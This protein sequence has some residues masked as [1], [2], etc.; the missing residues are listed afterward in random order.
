M[1]IVP[2]EE[3]PKYWCGGTLISNKLV[4]SGKKF[5][6]TTKIIFQQFN[7][8]YL[9]K[10]AAHCI[11]SKEGDNLLAREILVVLGSFKLNLRYEVGRETRSV[12][13]I[14]IHTDWNPFLTTYD[15]DIA[16]IEFEYPVTFSNYIQPICLWESPFD[17]SQSSGTVVGY[18]KSEDLTKIHEN[19]PK[20]IDVPI[21][22]QEEC[23]LSN[24]AL[25]PIS[26]TRTLCGGYRNGTGVCN[27][28]SGGGLVIQSNNVFYLRGIVS[29]S[30]IR[31]FS[32]DLQNYSIF[33]NVLKFKD[34]IKS[35]LIG[36][37]SITP[38]KVT[39]VRLTSSATQK[40]S[41]DECGIMSSSSGLIQNGEFSSRSEFPW[42]ASINDHTS[43]YN[44]SGALISRKHVVTRAGAV[45]KWND[46]KTKLTAFETSRFKIY[47][48]SLQHVSN[49][50]VFN[51]QEIILHPN[52]KNIDET[53]TNNIAII[54]LSSSVEFSDF[55][56]P[57]CLWAISDLNLVRKPPTF[58]VGYG[59]DENGI[60]TNVRKHA[61][62]TLMDQNE[63]EQKYSTWYKNFLSENKAFC[64]IGNENGSPCD[65]DTCLFVKFFGKWYL[66]GIILGKFPYPNG[67]CY[68]GPSYPF[69]YHDTAKNVDWIKN[70]IR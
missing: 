43:L 32:C 55:I 38:S 15:A 18:G 25:V 11:L 34:W 59:K 3:N 21:Q 65:F 42:M 62:V 28:D 33:T 50:N 70:I 57:V 36:Q 53:P 5:F 19:I 47:L 68:V 44:S 39:D 4:L 64:V 69:L 9:F 23:F 30:L 16:M 12:S 41:Y 27:G 1:R 40:K 37:T 66:R 22:T 61:K 49:Q 29:S 52:I 26:S 14:H 13:K 10:I 48:G 2:N 56:R 60:E 7:M 45:G 54:S 31:D 58:A 35:F 6:I 20:V 8:F 63:C 46:D 17:P 51:A 24:P 67:S